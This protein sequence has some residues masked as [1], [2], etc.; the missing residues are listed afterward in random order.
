MNEF[1]NCEIA[2]EI[3]F[4]EILAGKYDHLPE[5]AFY[6]VSNYLSLVLN[7]FSNNFSSGWQR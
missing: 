7:I 1:A 5:G 2:I 3:F 4:Q 6:M